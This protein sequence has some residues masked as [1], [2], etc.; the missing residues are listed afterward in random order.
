MQ[1]EKETSF[2][3]FLDKRFFVHQPKTAAHRSGMDAILLAASIEPQAGDR[4][5]DLGAGAGVAGLAVATRH[6]GTEIVLVE[7]DKVMLELA[8]RSLN[9]TENR[10][11]SGRVSIIEFDLEK[12][13]N[14]RR[15]ARIADGSFDFVIANPPFNHAG[16]RRS[17]N[18][19]RAA[20]HMMD[21]ATLPGWIDHA[22]AM[23][24][25]GGT[26]SLILR[27]ASL[28][29]V[30]DAL[31]PQFGAIQLLPLFAKS[32]EGAKRV[33]V[34]GRKGRKTGLSLLPG[35]VL[36]R[37]DGSWSEEAAAILRGQMGLGERKN[38]R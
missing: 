23:L 20:A 1:T 27:P 26:L 13:S 2:D 17:P 11:L 38:F 3:G 25:P 30:L 21:E 6:V 19:S 22:A 5:A 28:R 16:H 7:R 4:V 15:A 9:E 24:K 34:S 18:E 32:G 33:I 29:N 10:H 37:D 12:T 36:H 31:D 35:L 8:R 14:E